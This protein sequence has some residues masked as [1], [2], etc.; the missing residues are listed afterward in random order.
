MEHTYDT[1]M[2]RSALPRN[3]NANEIS[4]TSEVEVLTLVLLKTEHDQV[5]RILINCGENPFLNKGVE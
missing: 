3:V 1:F 2:R 5:H 4:A